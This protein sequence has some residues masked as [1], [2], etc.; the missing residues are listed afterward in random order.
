L[1]DCAEC[2]GYRGGSVCLG[3]CVVELPAPLV[4]YLPAAIR[5]APVLHWREYVLEAWL[6]GPC[7]RGAPCDAAGGAQAWLHA[8]GG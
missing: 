3:R 8:G 4:A 1:D 2:D 6:A 7:P 5:V